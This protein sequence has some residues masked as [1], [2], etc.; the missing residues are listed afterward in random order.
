MMQ[1][2]LVDD[3]NLIKS[4][5]NNLNISTKGLGDTVASLHNSWSH[6]VT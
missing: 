3:V 4:W 6:V 1:Y 5:A 2:Y